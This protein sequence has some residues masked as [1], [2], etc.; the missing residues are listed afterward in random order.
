MSSMPYK[1]N[2]HKEQRSWFLGSYA[3]LFC[4]AQV[5]EIEGV[6]SKFP[7]HKFLYSLSE[8]ACYKY[9]HPSLLL[10]YYYGCT[11]CFGYLPR[12]GHV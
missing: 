10:K 11:S 3:A 2:I 7:Q 5:L 1:Y 6:L 12:G 9:Y 8:I 4:W